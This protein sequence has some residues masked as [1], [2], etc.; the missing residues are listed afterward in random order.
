MPNGQDGSGF[1]STDVEDLEGDS[2]FEIAKNL[3]RSDR[4]AMGG[5]LPNDKFQPAEVI[6]VIDAFV[7][8]RYGRPTGALAGVLYGV[9]QTS[10]T[11]IIWSIFFYLITFAPESQINESTWALFSVTIGAFVLTS[12]SNLVDRY[13]EQDL[14]FTAFVQNSITFVSAGVLFAIS[15]VLESYFS[16]SFRLGLALVADIGYVIVNLIGSLLFTL[17]IWVLLKVL[18]RLNQ[19]IHWK[20]GYPDKPPYAEL[21]STLSGLYYGLTKGGEQSF[22]L[23][24]VLF[25]MF[26]ASAIIP[27][28]VTSEVWWSA[29]G[30]LSYIFIMRTGRWLV[31]YTR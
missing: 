27:F 31:S 22:L 25:S 19:L 7:S 6:W 4:E 20:T 28:I 30:V 2:I 23:G 21:Q 1:F 11:I 26:F 5:D 29:I 13:G 14:N 3:E 18:W 10:L 12:G 16:P 24:L 8:L 15:Y 17:S 9:L